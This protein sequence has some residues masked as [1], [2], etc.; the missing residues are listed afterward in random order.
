VGRGLATSLEFFY[1]KILYFYYFQIIKNLK[2]GERK[3][4]KDI[5]IE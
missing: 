2:M 1:V 5:E 4:R 3:N